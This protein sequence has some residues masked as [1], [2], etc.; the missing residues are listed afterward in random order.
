MSSYF[1]HPGLLCLK[2]G[3]TRLAQ[4]WL[5]QAVELFSQLDGHAHLEDF[6]EVLLSLGRS[7][8]QQGRSYV[9]HG[10]SYEQQQQQ[11]LY[12][13]GCY[14]WALLLSMGGG[15]LE[16]TYP[17]PRPGGGGARL[18]DAVSSAQVS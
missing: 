12:G 17:P 8:A 4:R 6:V 7:Y 10:R 16:R 3:A 11:L 18:N 2:A 14:E 5:S 1:L 15:L 13:T 9:Q